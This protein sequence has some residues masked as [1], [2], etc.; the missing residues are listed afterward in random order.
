MASRVLF[1]YVAYPPTDVA[2]HFLGGIAI[3]YF[4]WRA[5]VLASQS[6]PLGTIGLT[7]LGVM[8]F[9]LTCAAAVFW[10]FAEYLSDRW[11][12]T[13]AQL[14]LEDTLGDMLVGIMGGLA[15][16]LQRFAAR[17]NQ[18]GR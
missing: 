13:R 11:L 6:G 3:A 15:F 9:G 1:L 18:G 7:G 10:E 8:V 4:L 12:G 17:P 2:M 16:L 5:A 14:G